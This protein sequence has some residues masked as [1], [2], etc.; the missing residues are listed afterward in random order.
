VAG[1]VQLVAA[2]SHITRL[3]LAA[4]S[5]LSWR[6]LQHLAGAQ[7]GDGEPQEEQREEGLLERRRQQ[8]QQQGALFQGDGGSRQQAGG[9]GPAADAA[10]ELGLGRRPPAAAAGP[11]ERAA[12]ARRLRAA[13][14]R[15]APACTA[16]AA[17]VPCLPRQQAAG[18]LRQLRALALDSCAL[19][20]KGAS[21]LAA[22]LS[23]QGQ[24]VALQVGGRRGGGGGRGG[25]GGRYPR[26]AASAAAAAAG[27]WQAVHACAH[28][29]RS[30]W[31][32]QLVA[33]AVTGGCSGSVDESQL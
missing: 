1:L 8:Q 9:S 25:R 13:L 29:W 17:V 4:C 24:W 12:S 31:R 15:G 20:G 30:E 21:L 23:E 33:A 27:H 19:G 6:C 22:A 28:A 5:R 10:R 11:E 2:H 14:Q 16:A 7:P 18:L 32:W 26:Q 3:D